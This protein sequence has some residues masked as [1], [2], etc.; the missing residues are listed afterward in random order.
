MTR[1]SDELVNV[2]EAALGA[3]LEVSPEDRRIRTLRYALRA[4]DEANLE[5]TA[6]WCRVPLVDQRSRDFGRAYAKIEAVR[7]EL[8]DLIDTYSTGCPIQILMDSHKGINNVRMQPEDDKQVLRM[9]VE[10]AEAIVAVSKSSREGWHPISPHD[11]DWL[12]KCA[13]RLLET[14]RKAGK[15]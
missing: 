7:A 15:E 10:L 4:W 1:M 12:E 5:T 2:L 3:P 11:R 8:G 13:Q 9:A 14:V 6:R